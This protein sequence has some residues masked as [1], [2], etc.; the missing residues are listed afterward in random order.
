MLAKA[1]ILGPDRAGEAVVESLAHCTTCSASPKRV[2]DTTG[3]NTSR[4]LH[5]F[6]LL[7]GV[8]DQGRLEEEAVAG[9]DPS[10]RHLPWPLLWARSQNWPPGLRCR[11]EM[12][13][14]IPPLLAWDRPP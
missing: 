7:T 13:G 1:E 12:S 10:R 5:D 6:I 11:S 14:P 2:T 3:P 8:G 9:A 4:L